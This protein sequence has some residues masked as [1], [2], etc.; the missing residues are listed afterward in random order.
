MVLSTLGVAAD[1]TPS[2]IETFFSHYIN[3]KPLKYKPT[4]HI[5][6]HEGISLIRQFLSYAS[7]H[8]VEDI[9]AFTGQWVPCPTWVSM[10][11]VQIPHSFI[12]RS[13]EIIQSQLGPRGI[14]LVGGKEWWQ[15]RRP[16][17]PFT[18]E[19]IEMKSD[20]NERKAQG[21]LKSER[22]I[23]YVHGGAYYFGSTGEHRYQ[24]QRHARKLKARLLAPKYRLA[25]QFPFP[26]GLH[27]CIASY[28]YLIQDHD[29]NTVLLGGD[30]AG[31]GMVLAMLC[32]LR[33]Q[34]LPL[35]AGAILLSPWVDLT[36]SFPSVAGDGA[37]D[38]IPAMGFHHKPSTAW[39]PPSAAEWD[40]LKAEARSARPHFSNQTRPNTNQELNGREE[41][42]AIR[43]F[44]VKKADPATAPSTASKTPALKLANLDSGDTLSIE[45]DGKVIEIKDQIQMYAAN[46]LLA[47]PL[48]SPVMQPS[49]GG[50]P[51]LLIQVG[52]G[53][54]LRDE[55]IYLAH[56]AAH[57]SAY[58][59]P[60]VLSREFDPENIL[61][62]KYPPT[63]VQLQ[64]WDDLCHVAHTLSFTRPAKY[65]YRGV[66]QFGA[67]ALAHAQDKP[68][69][70]M[71]DD[72]ISVITKNSEDDEDYDKNSHDLGSS[73]LPNL[74]GD[75]RP[76]TAQVPIRAHTISTPTGEMGR[77]GDPLPPFSNNMIRQRVDRHGFIYPLQ[78]PAEI[79]ALHIDR[80]LIGVI[81]PGPV[82]K[83]ITKK[84]DWDH[85]FAKDKRRARQTLLKEMKEGYDEFE[86]ETPPPTALAGR[87][88][89]GMEKQ[90]MRKGKSWGLAM[91]SG[92]GSKHDESTIE[93]KK[94]FKRKPTQ[95]VAM[96]KAGEGIPATESPDRAINKA[97]KEETSSAWAT[98]ED[99][100][101]G[102]AVPLTRS[103]PSNTDRDV[104]TAVEAGTVGAV[105]TGMLAGHETHKVEGTEN[106]YLSDN[107]ARPH[108]GTIAYPFK[109]RN[110]P[111]ASVSTATLDSDLDHV[112]PMGMGDQES[113]M[114]GR[115]VSRLRDDG[116]SIKSG[117]SRTEA[118]GGRL[119]GFGASG[120]GFDGAAVDKEQSSAPKNGQGDGNEIGGHNWLMAGRASQNQ[121]QA[122]DDTSNSA[123]ERG[124]ESTN[125][126]DTNGTAAGAV[127]GAREM[128]E[129]HFHERQTEGSTE[130]G[131]HN[132]LVEGRNLSPSN[133]QVQNEN[134]YTATRAGEGPSVHHRP[135]LETF[136]TA[137]ES[138]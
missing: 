18:A 38:Y 74:D 65:M 89:K 60:D 61:L 120:T 116:S 95:S 31:G 87:R 37:L 35:P 93:R 129:P 85:R 13:A 25:P 137:R 73:A 30:S 107:N 9:Q 132:W 51:P 14:E 45:L 4:A 36:H 117:E 79:P 135:H 8:T 46:H 110:L 134:D 42:E 33:D 22:I 71:D 12:T 28:L 97:E 44:D 130:I 101:S 105:G 58:P 124:T 121:N 113:S 40:S 103:G 59:P 115:P 114:A 119:D 104:S 96:P 80:N 41:H 98:T 112:R 62:N 66:A 3:R 82:R 49:L 128:R 125:G 55:Q 64:V 29:P 126:I 111:G 76:S 131:S 11:E 67:W 70:I 92:W 78:P 91:W 88:Q 75:S 81:K 136:V 86:G 7:Q 21:K 63:K 26:C 90:K 23:L 32:T 54:L 138:L 122:H 19:W 6:Y 57:P 15:W 108:N 72:A 39:P 47:H 69:A 68:M 77:A 56:K 102:A 10:E 20:L 84:A 48:V 52:G 99:T 24:M 106:T 53:E 16:E 83:W 34:G 109:L 123:Q 2:V 17:I 100:S 118:V 94:A 27:D 1:V 127:D 43:G 133:K 50:L 5:S